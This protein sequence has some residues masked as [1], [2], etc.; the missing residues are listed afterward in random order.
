MK[1]G[2]LNNS[3]G[4]F[5]N[6]Y[7]NCPTCKIMHYI[8]CSRWSFNNNFEKPTFKP[9]LKLTHPNNGDCSH[10]LTGKTVELGEIEDL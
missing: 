6:Y 10:S 2:K 7:I 4:E 8:P 3:K 5:D 1:V 9:S